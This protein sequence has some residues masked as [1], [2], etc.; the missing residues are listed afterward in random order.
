MSRPIRLELL[1]SH[2]SPPSYETPTGKTE[3]EEQRMQET[4]GKRLKT[5]TALE[6]APCSGR[7]GHAKVKADLLGSGPRGW[8]GKRHRVCPRGKQTRPRPP[9]RR[10][11]ALDWGRTPGDRSSAPASPRPR[12]TPSPPPAGSAREQSG[13]RAPSLA[14]PCRPS[15]RRCCR[16][17]QLPQPGTAP[18]AAPM[19][20]AR[21]PWVQAALLTASGFRRQGRAR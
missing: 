14:P 11:A 17:C 4:P 3:G 9:W 20:S 18:A 5:K 2:P 13:W 19:P 21:L 16:V 6:T 12:T 7:R 10:R 1:K 15:L 8:K